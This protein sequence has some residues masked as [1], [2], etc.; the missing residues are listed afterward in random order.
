LREN[1][2]QYFDILQIICDENKLDE[3]RICSVDEMQKELQKAIGLVGSVASD[4]RAVNNNFVASVIASGNFVNDNG[5]S[6]EECLSS[7]K[8]VKAPE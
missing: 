3:T 8:H 2:N 5:S 6:F 4:E 1:V 7:W